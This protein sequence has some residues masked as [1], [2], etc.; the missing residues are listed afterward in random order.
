MFAA[1]GPPHGTDRIG[2]P[3]TCTLVPTRRMRRIFTAPLALGLLVLGISSALDHAVA[4]QAAP[5]A[6]APS[7]AFVPGDLLVQFRSTATSADRARIARAE[8]AEVKLEIAGT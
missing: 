8:G 7:P 4:A 6:T 2:V 3:M 5:L 1:S